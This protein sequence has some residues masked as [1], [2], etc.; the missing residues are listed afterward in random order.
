MDCVSNRSE[1]RQSK[2]TGSGKRQ[3]T[4]PCISR[5]RR[6]HRIRILQQDAVTQDMEGM[7][8]LEGWKEERK[9]KAVLAK[10]GHW[11]CTSINNLRSKI[12]CEND[13]LIKQAGTAQGS[14]VFNPAAQQRPHD[15]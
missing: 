1:R 14:T 9:E 6:R 10:T 11:C 2:K 13:R 5:L 3:R 12:E 7:V 8:C 4:W 15:E